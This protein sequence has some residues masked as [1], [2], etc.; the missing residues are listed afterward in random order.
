DDI[1]N[2]YIYL[3]NNEEC[4]KDGWIEDEQ[5]LDIPQSIYLFDLIKV[6]PYFFNFDSNSSFEYVRNDKIHSL[7]NLRIG[8][9]IK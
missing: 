5:I 7:S 3:I 6:F 4:E 8:L 9:K 2:E 1:T